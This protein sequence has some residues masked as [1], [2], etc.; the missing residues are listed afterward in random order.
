MKN[1]IK[2]AGV[3]VLALAPMQAGAVTGNIPFNGSVTHTC[4]IT[5]G[6]AGTI[7][8]NAGFDNL[9]SSNAGGGAGSASVASTGNGFDISVDAPT[10]SKPAADV[11]AETLTSS[12]STTGATTTSGTNA[13]AANSLNN[14]T[15]SVTIHM[16]AQ[17]GGT[18][19]FEAGA[20]TGQVVLRCE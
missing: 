14:G 7:T 15:A 5:V 3:A 17:K 6:P 4:V 1:L 16:N 8:A 9:S 18:D 20:Y 12:Y 10:L 13:T 2:V 11:T 19:V